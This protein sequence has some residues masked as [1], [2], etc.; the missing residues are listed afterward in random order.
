MTRHDDK[1]PE[2]DQ[3]SKPD[4]GR[5][6][7]PERPGSLDDTVV[8]SRPAAPAETE[9][10]ETEPTE[11]EP[12]DH[13]LVEELGFSES[14]KGFGLVA[15]EDSA[16]DDDET[17]P[18]REK[19]KGDTDTREVKPGK[20]RDRHD[21]PEDTT[22][23]PWGDPGPEDFSLAASVAAASDDEFGSLTGALPG[24]AGSAMVHAREQQL[25]WN[26]MRFEQRLEVLD[27]LREEL[28]SH[29][30]DHVSSLATAILRPTLEVL[31]GEYLPVLEALRTLEDVVPPLLVAHHAPP[32]PLLAEGL[33]SHVRMAPWGVVVIACGAT[34]PF[35]LPVT[36]AIDALATGNSVIL[37]M[38]GGNPRLTELCQRLFRRAEF[39]ERLVQVVSSDLETVEALVDAAPDK[40]L[41]RGDPFSAARLAAAAAAR[42]ANF[43]YLKASKPVA[44]VLPGAPVERAIHAI[45]WGAYAG[46]GTLPGAIERVVV[47]ADVYDEF[48]MGFMEALRVMNSHHAQLANIKEVLNHSRFRD[49]VSDAVTRGA[50]ATWPAGEVPGRW[51]HWK[52]GVLE[53]VPDDAHV[54]VHSLEGPAVALY[55]AADPLAEITRLVYLAPAGNL[56]VFG[57]RSEDRAMREGL[58][59][60]PA[61]RLTIHEPGP[62]FGSA[63]LWPL[64]ADVPRH[65]GGPMA[66]LRPMLVSEGDPLAGRIEWFPYTDDK[67]EALM[68]AM[69]AHYGG[70]LST[71]LK[72]KLRL[73]INSAKRKLLRGDNT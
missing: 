7:D 23:D 30:D 59:A 39:P 19:V 31:T 11:P 38:P 46:G 18:A 10:T 33:S 54:S 48:R 24:I 12:D 27:R 73:G 4:T 55:R 32:S 71:R 58:E 41:Y 63:M 66:M 34:S 22:E 69:E 2:E 14:A 56:S 64:G 60:L 68:D 3:E 9:P 47:H 25:G 72:S 1:H 45:M 62:H 17:V 37:C 44:A 49:L 5:L 35:A 15:D 21:E 43:Q 16:E 65:H 53:N 20:G 8:P 50:R 36:L 42:G 70:K 6:A 57:L 61:A 40:V 67:A 28:V 52:A 26:R 51:I 13:S 29:R